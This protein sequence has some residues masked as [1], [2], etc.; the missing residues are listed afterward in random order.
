M[1]ANFVYLSIS[2]RKNFISLLS[3]SRESIWLVDVY[4]LQGCLHASK[5][6]ERREKYKMMGSLLIYRGRE[7]YKVRE[8]KDSKYMSGDICEITLKH[9]LE[10]AA[11]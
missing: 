4:D 11:L 10:M 5:K 6:R 1:L 2:V 7:G 9:G 3:A 8:N